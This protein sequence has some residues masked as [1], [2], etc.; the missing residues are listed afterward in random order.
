MVQRYVYSE[1]RIVTII[2]GQCYIEK[3]LCFKLVEN[4]VIM[5][6]KIHADISSSKRNQNEAKIYYFWIEGNYLDSSLCRF[7]YVNIHTTARKI[8]RSNVKYISINR[9][10]EKMLH[11]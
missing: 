3:V 9:E 10:H 4:N 8:C 5:F 6:S 7:Y 2:S 11:I 1:S